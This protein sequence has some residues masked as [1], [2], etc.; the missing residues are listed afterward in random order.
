[1]N[2]K[3]IL[4]V[5]VL[6]ISSLAFAQDSEKA[7]KL[8]DDVYSKAKGYENIQIDFKY[9]L[10]NPDVGINQETR[11]DVTLQGNKYLL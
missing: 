2:Y 7:K 9:V 10:E 3:Y 8:L 11:G 6:L 4:G 1:M 5:L